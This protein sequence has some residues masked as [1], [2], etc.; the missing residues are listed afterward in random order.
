MVCRADFCDAQYRHLLF[1]IIVPLDWGSDLSAFWLVLFQCI[2]L[3]FPE[4]SFYQTNLTAFLLES[5]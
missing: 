2:L 5:S 3:T 1:L 4:T